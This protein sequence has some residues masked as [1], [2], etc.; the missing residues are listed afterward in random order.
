MLAEAVHS[1]ADSG[2]TIEAKLRVEMPNLERIY[3]EIGASDDRRITTS[4][5]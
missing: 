4:A 3:V 1:L 2:D 5:A